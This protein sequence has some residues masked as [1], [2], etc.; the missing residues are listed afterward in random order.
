MGRDY[1]VCPGRGKRALGRVRIVSARKEKLHRADSNV[2][3]QAEGFADRW[4]FRCAWEAINGSFDPEA[5]VWR[6]EF[7]VIV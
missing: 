4:Q 7:E 2:E 3:A 6:V 1:A 5:V